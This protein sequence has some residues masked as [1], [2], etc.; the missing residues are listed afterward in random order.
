MRTAV[1]PLRLVAAA[2]RDEIDATDTDLA[3]VSVCVAD[4]SGV[5]ETSADRAITV[6]IDGPA[7]L[8]GFA[9]ADPR[10][11]ESYR[12]ATSTTYEGRALAVI[13]PTGPGTITVTFTADGLEAATVQVTARPV[14][15]TLAP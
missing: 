12:S 10:S 8:Q 3:Y 9:S 15:A 14:A 2:D 5:I 6:T 11:L 13:R 7:T 4:A 1:G